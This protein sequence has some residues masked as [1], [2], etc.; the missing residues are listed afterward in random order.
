MSVLCICVGVSLSLGVPVALRVWVSSVSECVPLYCVPVFCFL[1]TR[2]AS[3]CWT[4]CPFALQSPCLPGDYLCPPGLSAGPRLTSLQCPAGYTGDNCEGDVDECAS[5]P[6]QNG[7]FCIDLVAR[8]LCSCPPGTLGTPGPGLGDRMGGWLSIPSRRLPHL[9]LPPKVCSVRLM[10]TTVA[11]AHPW[12]RAPGAC[13][14]VPVWTSW[15]AFAAPAPPGTLACAARRTSMSVTRVPATMHTPGIVCR[16]QVGASAAFVV[17][18][19]Q[20]S[21]GEV[22]ALGSGPCSYTG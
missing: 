22:A 1:H 12:T 14:M 5:Q 20:V 4:V 11:Q 13:T 9:S 19:S 6:C 3:V 7:G 16:T 18:A 17:R 8:Y 15:V 2:H 21:V 10:R